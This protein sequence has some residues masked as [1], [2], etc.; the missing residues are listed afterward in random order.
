VPQSLHL[1]LQTKLFPSSQSKYFEQRKEIEGRLANIMAPIVRGL[2]CPSENLDTKGRGALRLDGARGRSKFGALMFE[3]EV[4][5]KQMYCIEESTCEIVDFLAPPAVIW[6]PNSDSAPRKLR[7]A[8]SPRYATDKRPAH[9]I[10][11]NS[12]G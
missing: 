4:F 7:P 10:T 12:P 2:Y 5:R 3:T 1:P 8:C 9:E 11:I 6:R